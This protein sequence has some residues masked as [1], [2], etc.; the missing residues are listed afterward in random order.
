MIKN[1]FAKKKIKTSLL[2]NE[3]VHV[4]Y[5]IKPPNALHISHAHLLSVNDKHQLIS[6]AKTATQ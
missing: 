4:R 3:Y 2:P 5:K 6:I 1:I